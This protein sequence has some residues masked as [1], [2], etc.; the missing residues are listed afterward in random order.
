MF[1][2]DTKFLFQDK[3]PSDIEAQIN[4]ELIN[5]HKWLN[6]NKLTLNKEKTKNLC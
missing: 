4:D 5:V 1:A 6:A 2:D 3:S